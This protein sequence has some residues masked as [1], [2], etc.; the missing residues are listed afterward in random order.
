MVE[1]LNSKNKFPNSNWILEFL[2][3]ENCEE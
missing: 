2:K 1:I 3:F